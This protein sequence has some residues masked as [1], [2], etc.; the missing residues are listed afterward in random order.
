LL[1]HIM[2]ALAVGATFLLKLFEKPYVWLPYNQSKGKRMENV[3]AVILAAGEGTRMRSPLS[4]LIH[5]VCYQSLVEFP[6]KVCMESG[7]GSQGRGIESK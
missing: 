4:K 7:I 6:A 3:K 1:L 5:R 2:K